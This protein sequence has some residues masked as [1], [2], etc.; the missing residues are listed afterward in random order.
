MNRRRS[1]S[2]V[3]VRY[4]L[5]P[6]NAVS[7]VPAEMPEYQVATLTEPATSG[8][9]AVSTSSTFRGDVNWTIWGT[10]TR[11]PSVCRVSASAL[12]RAGGE[13][14]DEQALRREE[15]DDDRQR[16]DHGSG[17]QHRRR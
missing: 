4:G 17:H 15:Q 7:S 13:P 12:F 14:T 11:P 9:A 8:A 3:D 10:E 6:R 2:H 16:E 1:A 5:V